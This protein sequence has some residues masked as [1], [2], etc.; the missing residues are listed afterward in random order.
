MKNTV[1]SLTCIA[2]FFIFMASP[3]FAESEYVE[4][5]VDTWT[6][7]MI[8][9]STVT[10]EITDTWVSDTGKTHIAYGIQKPDNVEFQVYYGILWS[11]HYYIEATH[12]QTM[13]D[14]PQDLS[15]YTELV[16]SDDFQYF[17]ARSGKYPIKSGWKGDQEPDIEPSPCVASYLLGHEDPRL[18]ILRKFRDEKMR[19]GRAGNNMIELYYDKSDSIIS[20]C[21]K[22]P[23]LRWSLKLMLEAVIPVI[24]ML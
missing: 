6:V 23:S 12:D 17:V 22:N 24:G 3:G 10:W 5:W 15:E 9:N 16:P 4:D 14:L 2:F 8:D 19:S 7:R 18:D 11:K 20:I 21:E 13:Y 1:K